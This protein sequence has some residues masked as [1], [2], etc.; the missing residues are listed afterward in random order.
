MEMLLNK[1]ELLDLGKELQGVK[2]VCREGCCWITLPGDN[3]D[4][5]VKHGNSFIVRSKG[6]VIITAMESCRL[7]LTDSQSAGRLDQPFTAIYRLLRNCMANSFDT[8]FS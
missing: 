5:I 1:Q 3:R 7:M 2:I 6:H 8:N 4:H